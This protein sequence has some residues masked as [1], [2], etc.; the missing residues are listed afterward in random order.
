M[1]CSQGKGAKGALITTEGFRDVLEIGRCNRTE[2]YNALYKKPTPLVP[3]HLQ[4]EVDERI[5]PVDEV[6]V[7]LV[8]EDLVSRRVN[9]LTK[10]AD[11]ATVRHDTTC[12]DSNADWRRAK[13]P[14]R[15]GRLP[16]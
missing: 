2:M 12:T 3:R 9:L 1:L 16:H 6:L 11:R 14:G 15:L 8:E 13:D 10:D 7:P 4:L 5:G